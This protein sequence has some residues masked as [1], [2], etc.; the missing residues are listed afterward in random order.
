M[1]RI[2][3]LVAAALS[4]F[5]STAAYADGQRNVIG[6]WLTSAEESSFDEGGR[7][8]AMTLNGSSAL[9]VRCLEKSLSLGF[10]GDTGSKI[11]TGDKVGIRLRTDKNPI[12]DLTGFAI[13]DDGLIQ[14]DIEPETVKMIR[15]G[16]ETAIRMEYEGTTSV[17]VFKTNGNKAAF[18]RL[19]KECD[20]DG[21]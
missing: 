14:I 4:L 13:T 9:A 20:V 17:R 6:N 5:A 10:N 3:I 12:V 2:S 18:A 16:K 21:K 7:Y 1:K 8:F 19:A 15:D 11:A